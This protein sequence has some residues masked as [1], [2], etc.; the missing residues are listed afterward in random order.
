MRA[1]VVF[2]ILGA[3]TL[4]AQGNHDDG[5]WQGYAGE[6]GYSS[7]QLVSLAEAIPAEKY[8]WR[9]APGVRSVSEVYMHIVQANF[10][11]LGF[12]GAAVPEEAKSTPLEKSVTA[13]ADV[14]AWLKRSIEAVRTAH[15]GAK[16]ADLAR[17]VKILGREATVDGI[18]LRILV[19]AH[20]H[21]GQLVAYARM[22]GVVPPWS[23]GGGQ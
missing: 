2:V 20:E 17:K 7:R 19:H 10:A 12:T 21:M 1:I 14:I 9:P 4:R 16:S 8:A 5:L 15:A 6:W 13:K 22:V 3:L 18:Y 23:A 11:L